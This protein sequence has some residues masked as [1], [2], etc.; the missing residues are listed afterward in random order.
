MLIRFSVSNFLS[1]DEETVFDM[2]ASSSEEHPNH[3]GMTGNVRV[4]KN[5]AIYGA[6]G[7]GK[8]NLVLAI[9]KFIEIIRLGKLSENINT[10][11]FK[12][13]P[14]NKDLP[15]KFEMEFS[16]GNTMYIYGIECNHKIIEHEWLIDTTSPDSDERLLERKT[17]KS[18]D[19]DIEFCKKW[20]ETPEQKSINAVLKKNLLR[21]D[22]LILH[23]HETLLID[24]LSEIYEYLSKNIVIVKRNFRP[25]SYFSFL[26]TEIEIEAASALIRKFDTGISSIYIDEIDLDSILADYKSF[27]EKY[28]ISLGQEEIENA[29][30][31]AESMFRPIGKDSGFI[32]IND[33]VVFR[34]IFYNHKDEER[35]DIPFTF[36][37]E[38]DGTRKIFE[39]L[40]LFL[41]QSVYDA[42]YIIDEIDNSLHPHLC[43]EFVKLLMS[44][45]TENSHNTFIDFTKRK[46]NSQIIFTTHQP[47]LLTR[48]LFRDDE[49]WFVEK[50]RHKG[51]TSLYPLFEFDV[52][53]DFNIEDGYLLGRFGGVPLIDTHTYMQ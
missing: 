22:E 44:D 3:V 17:S 16:I 49:I 11:K 7:S 45:R 4:V 20:D 23:H 36:E 52:K 35:N 53:A 43:Y 8:S 31:L 24:E 37:E 10:Y 2:L 48:E 50:D 21:D 14:K 5:A 46:K 34:K 30:N 47:N 29:K 15:V 42:V 33:K 41:D 12:L 6:N 39:F 51:N 40:P 38:S 25:G 1:F 9:H 18:R 19:Y 28:N 13:N 26:R 32:R 27:V